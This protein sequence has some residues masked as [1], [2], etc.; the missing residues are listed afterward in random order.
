MRE[1]NAR[2]IP[3]IE[4]VLLSGRIRKMSPRSLHIFN[5]FI[6]HFIA[7]LVGPRVPQLI[8]ASSAVLAFFRS[9]RCDLPISKK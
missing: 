2:L 5:R 3:A 8:V 1:V 6:I 9:A 4:R 7:S